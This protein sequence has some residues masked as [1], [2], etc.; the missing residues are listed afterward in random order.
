MRVTN[1]EGYNEPRDS[2]ARDWS[3]YFIKA[4]PE[5]KFLFIP[6]IGIEAVNFIKKW[7]INVLVITT[8]VLVHDIT[9]GVVA[10]KKELYFKLWV[11]TRAGLVLAG[12]VNDLLSETQVIVLDVPRVDPQ[13]EHFVVGAQ[14]VRVVK[15]KLYVPL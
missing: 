3:N 11:E 2:I 4:F 6:N 5:S 15:Y 8:Y 7:D 9:V 13:V 12:L 1:A 14:L 10:F